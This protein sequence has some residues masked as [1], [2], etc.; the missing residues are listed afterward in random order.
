M[1]IPK[2][3]QTGSEILKVVPVTDFIFCAFI[4]D[5]VKNHAREVIFYSN[6]NLSIIFHYSCDFKYFITR[7]IIECDN[8]FILQMA[9][10]FSHSI[11]KIFQLLGNEQSNNERNTMEAVPFMRNCDNQLKNESKQLLIHDQVFDS[12]NIQSDNEKLSLWLKVQ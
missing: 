4:G 3:I 7:C 6:E 12:E 9:E 1:E 10:D 11:M 2:S 5:Q 8:I